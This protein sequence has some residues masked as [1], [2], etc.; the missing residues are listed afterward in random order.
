VNKKPENGL[1]NELHEAILRNQGTMGSTYRLMCEGIDKATEIVEKG[2]AANVGVVS[3][4]KSM[5]RTILEGVIP[6]SPSR[7]WRNGR[8]IGGLLRDNPELS[9][10][11]K[12]Y[13]IYLRD[14]L[15]E[16]AS[17]ESAQKFEDSEIEKVSNELE[18]AIDFKSGV[19]VYTFPT[20]FKNPVK[21]D[22]E[23]FWLK[24]GR[25]EQVV[26]MRIA[27]QTRQTAMP[28]DPWI[29]RVYQ[30]DTVSIP[31]LEQTFHKMLISAGHIRTEARHGG[32][33]W[34]ATNL[35]YLDQIA[36]MLNLKIM[37]NDF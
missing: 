10:P 27:N 1:T 20:Y 18:K 25:T 34:F 22:P 24:I 26:E 12:E 29:L 21:K 14:E 3:N 16:F 28:E 36:E 31:E 37:K 32:K 15:D 33:E 30:S 4:D 35:E 5:I 13:L 9:F 6:N 23:R 2:S 17:N 7:A 11:V 8:A 19:Y